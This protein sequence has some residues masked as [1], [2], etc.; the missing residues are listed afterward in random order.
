MNQQQFFSGISMD[1][2]PQISINGDITLHIHPTVT[3]VSE[4][5]KLIA[6]QV[7]PLAKTSTREIDTVIKAENGKIV[8]LGGPGIPAECR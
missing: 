2:T 5:S 1:I 8:V 7:V 6:G 3:S 4:Q